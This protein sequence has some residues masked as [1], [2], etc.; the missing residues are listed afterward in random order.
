MSQLG[1][2]TLIGRTR[3]WELRRSHKFAAALAVVFPNE[4]A[5]HCDGRAGPGRGVDARADELKVL[6]TGPAANTVLDSVSDGFFVR[7]FQPAGRSHQLAAAG[8]A[9]QRGRG[10][11]DA[12][13][14]IKSE[15]PVCP[16]GDLAGGHYTL[17]WVVKTIPT[18]ARIEQGDVPFSIAAPK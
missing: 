10:D 8:Q 18:D 2:S 15:C 13:P 16:R 12:T 7:F 9:R 17:H 14:A 6:E 1:G 3:A 4:T 11:V 5:A